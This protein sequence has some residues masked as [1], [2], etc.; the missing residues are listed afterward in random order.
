[1][2]NPEFHREF[3]IQT[4]HLISARRPDLIII[5][6]KERICRI[7]DFALPAGH[8]V[9]LKGYE[10]RDKYF[11]LARELKKTVEHESD[12]NTNC[13][14][15]SLYSHQRIGTRAGGLTNNGTGGDCSNYS[16]IE[17]GHN[18]EKSSGDLCRLAFTQTPVENH[19]LTLMWKTLKE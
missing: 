12:D 14:W 5:N 17:I 3:E 19:Q 10:K 8:R 16:I 4:H 6:K 2:H 13:N 18:T 11:D 7:V 15:S 1:M 9:K